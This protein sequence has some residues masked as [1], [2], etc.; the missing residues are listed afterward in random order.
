MFS[1]VLSSTRNHAFS[2]CLIKSFASIFLAKYATM[3]AGTIALTLVQFSSAGRKPIGIDSLTMF[4][5][6]TRQRQCFELS[7]F[8][9]KYGG[10][11][12]I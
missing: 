12:Q 1:V 3:R 9:L 8:S 10:G 6:K 11:I 4:E 2:F 5:T 7:S